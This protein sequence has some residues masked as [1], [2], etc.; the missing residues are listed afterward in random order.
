METSTEVPVASALRAAEQVAAELR[1]TY[2][3]VAAGVVLLER[4]GAGCTHPALR[5]AR[6][7]GGDALDLA[8]EVDQQV[9]DG[10][11]RLRV[12]AGHVEP[13][14]IG[15]LVE[16]L[17]TVRG[18]WSAAAD[19]IRHLP[20][21]VTA[22]GQ[23]L[24]DAAPAEATPTDSTGGTTPPGRHDTETTTRQWRYAAEQLDLMA[25]CL[26]A[27]VAALGSYTD[28]LSGAAPRP[29]RKGDTG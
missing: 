4:V 5:L 1:E 26:A 7:S 20:G 9:T 18:R 22:A 17:D 27:A 3:G 10:I 23:Q 11:R 21:R 6:R 28:G 12:A 15:D 14:T 16:T 8:A 13:G 2:L 25:E 19:R 24:R 29:A